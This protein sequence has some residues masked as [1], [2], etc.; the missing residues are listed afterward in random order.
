MLGLIIIEGESQKIN[1]T[2]FF[3]IIQLFDNKKTA[4]KTLLS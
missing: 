3:I 2:P 1:V 4:Q